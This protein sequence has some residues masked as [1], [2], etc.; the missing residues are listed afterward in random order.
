MIL[1]MMKTDKKESIPQ[2]AWGVTCSPIKT[3]WHFVILMVCLGVLGIT[4][5]YVSK[6]VGEIGER[7]DYMELKLIKEEPLPRLRG[8][9]PTMFEGLGINK[10]GEINEN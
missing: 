5:A 8:D 6:Y 1:N 3:D 2:A 7:V 10:E 4:M 9:Q